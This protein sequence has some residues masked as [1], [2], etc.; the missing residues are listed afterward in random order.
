VDPVADPLLL[1]KSGSAGNRTR[2]VESL[3]KN[4]GHYTT[5]ADYFLLQIMYKFSSYLTG[6][7]ILDHRG[8]QKYNLIFIFLFTYF[9][10]D[11]PL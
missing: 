5:E 11:R 10:Y 7:T 4:S 9:H 3:A 2:T 6:S 8:V 1:R